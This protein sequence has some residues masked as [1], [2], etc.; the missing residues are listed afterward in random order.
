LCARVNREEAA[1]ESHDEIAVEIEKREGN[2]ILESQSRNCKDHIEETHYEIWIVQ[3]V[4]R[5]DQSYRVD[6]IF[7]DNL[8]CTPLPLS[9]S[10]F[11]FVQTDPRMPKI[12]FSIVRFSRKNKAPR[13]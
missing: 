1:E 13:I 10:V 3:V 11:L 9:P 6:N 5:I 4:T 12:V 8:L 7:V 2:C